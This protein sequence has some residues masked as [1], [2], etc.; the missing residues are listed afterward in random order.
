MGPDLVR[1]EELRLRIPGLGQEE[2][3]R[4]AQD[5]TRRVTEGLSAEVKREQLGLVDLRLSIPG[6][7]TR[8]QLAARIAEGILQQLQ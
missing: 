8:D 2:A 7:T 4:L 6:G 5:V 1:I 3:R